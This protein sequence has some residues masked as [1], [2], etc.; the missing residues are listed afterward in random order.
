M[1]MQKWH[2]DPELEV[3]TWATA[4]WY[5]RCDDDHVASKSRS[6]CRYFTSLRDP[7]ERVLSGYIYFCLLCEEDNRYCNKPGHYVS[8]MPGSTKQCPTN[9][10]FVDWAQMKQNLYTRHFA[11]VWN[12][13]DQYYAEVH[14]NAKLSYA[15]LLSH[16]VTTQQQYDA[17]LAA[18]TSPNMLVLWSDEL[19]KKGRLG[20]AY[21][22][23]AA[24]LADPLTGNEKSAASKAS[25]LHVRNSKEPPADTKTAVARASV[26]TNSVHE[27]VFV[28]TKEEL[29][30]VREIN[31]FDIRLY[32][33]LRK[34]RA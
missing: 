4:S 8:L 6:P 2:W 9:V 13:T 26:A 10:T 16:S 31:A 21:S 34:L 27:R 5:G 19:G 1:P 30:Q 29:E 20:P 24:W 15:K 7:I 25:S 14:W 22:K 11:R 28:P 33:A 18:L 3:V 23:L 32:E 17:A 12:S